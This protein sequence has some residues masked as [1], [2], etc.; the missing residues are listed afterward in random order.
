MV[1]ISV[2]VVDFNS[3]NFD[4]LSDPLVWIMLMQMNIELSD[5]QR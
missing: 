3:N 5:K 1:Y 2:L 4:N